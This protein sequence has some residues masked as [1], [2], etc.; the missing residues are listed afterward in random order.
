[1]S[2]FDRKKKVKLTFFFLFISS[3]VL[4]AVVKKFSLIWYEKFAKMSKK[5]NAA[6]LLFY[7]PKTMVQSEFVQFTYLIKIHF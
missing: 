4:V 5:K 1:M 7:V 3:D 6:S 2:P